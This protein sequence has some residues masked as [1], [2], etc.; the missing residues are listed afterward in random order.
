[1]ANAY[2]V[3]TADGSAMAILDRV[4]VIARSAEEAGKK[5][6]KDAR[7][8]TKKARIKSIIELPDRLIA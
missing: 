8:I 5:A 2:T 7:E 4:I 6:L 1:M 3:E